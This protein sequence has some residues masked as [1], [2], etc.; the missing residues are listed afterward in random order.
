MSNEFRDSCDIGLLVKLSGTFRSQW[1]QGFHVNRKSQIKT[2]LYV[3]QSKCAYWTYR[4]MQKGPV[5]TPIFS[6][7]ELIEYVLG[8]RWFKRIRYKRGAMSPFF[9]II[10]LTSS[11]AE[12]IQNLRTFSTGPNKEYTTCTSRRELFAE[13]LICILSGN[14]Y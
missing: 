8:R 11:N 5:Q 12:V 9:S 10:L 14:I 3:N 6:W 4:M 13:S 1:L 7:A 2:M